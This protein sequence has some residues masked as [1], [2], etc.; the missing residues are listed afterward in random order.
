MCITL[1]ILF[2]K[3]SSWCVVSVWGLPPYYHVMGFKILESFK[4]QF[5]D[6]ADITR[7][8][9]KSVPDLNISQHSTVKLSRYHIYISFKSHI[10]F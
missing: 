8:D 3:L 6:L 2:R 1:V 10:K 7:E 5:C 9:S 4:M